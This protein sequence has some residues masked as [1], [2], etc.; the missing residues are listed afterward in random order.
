M[1]TRTATDASGNQTTCMFPVVV[2]P[3]IRSRTP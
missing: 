3:T 2:M 1:V